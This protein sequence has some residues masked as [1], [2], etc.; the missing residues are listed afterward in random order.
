MMWLYLNKAVGIIPAG[1][2]ERFD[3]RIAAQLILN[4]MARH[5]GGGFPGD[6]RSGV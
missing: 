3:D 6:G 2:V 4:G 1:T 5:G